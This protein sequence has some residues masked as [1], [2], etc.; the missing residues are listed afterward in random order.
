M[1]ARTAI[2]IVLASASVPLSA[3]S[4][5]TD[6]LRLDLNIPAFELTVLRDS[7]AVRRF[8]VGIGMRRYPTPTGEFWLTRI[9]WNPWWI[10]PPSDWARDEEITPPGPEN[11][12]G[13]VK[14]LL[15]GSL[16]LHATPIR[17]SIGRA[18]SH[19]CVRMLEEDAIE[20]ARLV[21]S[22]LGV[23]E[24]GD[25]TL[26]SS[27]A[28]TKSYDLQDSI[29]ATLRY[30]TLVVRS[31]SLFLYPDVYRRSQG[32][33]RASIISALAGAG[34]DTTALDN[35]AVDEALNRV[36]EVRVVRPLISFRRRPGGVAVIPYDR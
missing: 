19:S 24:G 5:S 8:T 20:L 23:A 10:P 15:G 13:K 14:L 9:V 35:E 16:Y 34:V 2:R 3:T 29:P 32:L 26:L 7:V 22:A 1:L 4:Q 30:E 31:D 6:S 25:S 18:E 28:R 27:W 11:P 17:S 33:T 12:M 21:Q 36:R